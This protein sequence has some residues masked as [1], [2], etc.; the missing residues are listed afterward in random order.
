MHSPDDDDVVLFF[1][2]RSEVSKRLTD[3][4]FDAISFHTLSDFLANGYPESECIGF[5]IA[6]VYDKIAVPILPAIL[7]GPLEFP[8]FFESIR[9]LHVLHVSH[10]VGWFS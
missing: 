8:T 10:D 6:C 9:V 2:C 1:E 7:I 4:S 5:G 3:E